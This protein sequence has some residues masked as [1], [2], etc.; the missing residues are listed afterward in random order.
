MTSKTQKLVDELAKETG[1]RLTAGA[2]HSTSFVR[3]DIEVVVTIE[4]RRARAAPADVIRWHAEAVELLKEKP[5]RLNDCHFTTTKKSPWSR[6]GVT[7]S[8]RPNHVIV[9]KSYANTGNEHCF[10]F[11]CSHHAEK[12]RNRAIA[13]FAL[14]PAAL[15]EIRKIAALREEE[16]CRKAR[17][18]DRAD[19]EARAE[20][21]RIE[22]ARARGVRPS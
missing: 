18:R 22:T 11:A 6:S 10:D 16:E 13:V 3:D 4:V 1:L 20:L 14:L 7:C 21:R 17:E 8:L 15:A 5:Y 2:R 9:M 12:M 19:D